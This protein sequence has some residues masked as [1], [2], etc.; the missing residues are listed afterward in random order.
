MAK[1]R[2]PGRRPKASRRGDAFGPESMI[3]AWS[4]LTDTERAAVEGHVWFCLICRSSKERWVVEGL[5]RLGMAASFTP[6]IE[7][8]RRA[9]R[10]SR[11][12]DFEARNISRF[13]G[14]VFAGV[15]NRDAPGLAHAALTGR[16]VDERGNEKVIRI[17]LDAKGR[18]LVRGYL[19]DTRG[20]PVVIARDAITRMMALS[21]VA[22]F[23]KSEGAVA[24]YT[25]LAAGD[26]LEAG[27]RCELVGPILRG[28]HAVVARIAGHEAVLRMGPGE[29][30]VPAKW[31]RRTQGGR[32]A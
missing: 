27:D 3:R 6:L 26:V 17:L 22:L 25:P 7:S 30:R 16:L 14:L 23:A 32:A 21:K 15:D 19:S 2:N 29:V 13:P 31:L 18:P 4:V 28:E 9:S 5:R 8:E 10:K 24:T 12:K 20:R 1:P 11:S